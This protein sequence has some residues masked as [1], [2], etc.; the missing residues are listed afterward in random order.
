MAEA[1]GSEL[2]VNKYLYIGHEQQPIYQIFN[3]KTNRVSGQRKTQRSQKIYQKNYGRIK[4]LSS[5]NFSTYITCCNLVLVN[6]FVPHF[7][8]HLYRLLVS[9]PGTF[10]PA[11]KKLRVFQRLHTHALAQKRAHPYY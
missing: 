11:I 6:I 8:I 3:A 1:I 7:R 10:I 2:C 9:S 4:P 5:R